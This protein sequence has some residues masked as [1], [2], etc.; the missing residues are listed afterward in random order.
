M[1]NAVFTNTCSP[2][3]FAYVTKLQTFS[4]DLGG[5]CAK[6]YDF[7]ISLVYIHLEWP[8]NLFHKAIISAAMP[9]LLIEI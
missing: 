9:P 5:N 1:S 7:E 4:L 6:R 2:S 3:P 8:G